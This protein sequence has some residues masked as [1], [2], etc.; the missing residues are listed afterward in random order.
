MAG[1]IVKE[2]MW[3]KGGPDDPNLGRW[4]VMAPENQ[5]MIVDFTTPMGGCS[6]LY[7]SFVFWLPKLDY[8]VKK[9]DEK[10]DIS[11]IHA[12]IYN[13]FVGQ[14]EKIE[15]QIKSGLASAAQ[16]VADYEL[17]EHDYRRYNE[18][19][20]YFKEGKKDSHVLR[21]LFVDRV[22][23]YTGEGF[24]LITMAKRWPTIITDFIRMGNPIHKDR[25]W[26]KIED[27]KNALDVPAAEAT[28]LKTK[29]ELFDKWRTLFLPAVKD[30]LVRIESLRKARKRSVEEYRTWLKPYVARHKM[31]KDALESKPSEGFSNAYMLPAFGQ[32]SM[33]SAVRLWMWKPF[34]R[35]EPHKAESIR[36]DKI[37]EVDAYDDLVKEWH[38][39]IEKMYNVKISREEIDEIIENDMRFGE[40][41]GIGGRG[42]QMIDMYYIF[43]DINITRSVIKTPGGS[44]SENMMFN[45]IKTYLF[46]Q[47]AMLINLIEVK[48]REKQ[49]EREVNELIGVMDEESMMKD[50]EDEMAGKK[51][52]KKKEG[53]SGKLN[54][55]GGGI[56]RILRPFSKFIVRGG[57]Y[58]SN[59]K[60]RVT[61]MYMVTSGNLY[62]EIV[63]FVKDRMGV[64]K[65]SVE[66]YE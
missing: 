52:P 32:A 25:D 54:R 49:F 58:E 40:P 19:W 28:V 23:A 10:M 47:N 41:T 33:G 5:E 17:I 42:V 7:W 22:D 37:S 15:G 53:V 56:K 50:L 20:E 16:S 59:M 39:K 48:A 4:F 27:I 14:K 45:P 57:P 11:P 31:M 8:K 2:E 24:S 34:I 18:V 30:R 12:E 65:A 6:N 21:S 63:E 1:P 35:P 55:A 66:V 9:V 26:K 13:L 61:K 38:K 44:E 29:N 64:G 60:E 36:H 43:F 62:G 3:N 46:S 51:K